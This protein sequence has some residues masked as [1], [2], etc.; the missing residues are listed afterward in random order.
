MKKRGEEE[1]KRGREEKGEVEE[2]R[3]EGGQEK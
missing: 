2:R 3:S 1:W